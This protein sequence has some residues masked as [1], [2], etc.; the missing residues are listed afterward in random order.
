MCTSV[1]EIKCPICNE[2]IDQNKNRIIVELCG[3]SKCRLCFIT[4]ENGCVVC[5]K[6]KL[7]T[8][9]GI[10]IG[11]EKSTKSGPT[12]NDEQQQEYFKDEN[13]KRGSENA[14][15]SDTNESDPAVNATD[16]SKRVEIL[17]DVIIFPKTVEPEPHQQQSELSTAQVSLDEVHPSDTEGPTTSPANSIQIAIRK[18]KTDERLRT[19]S[20]IEVI[21]VDQKIS[22]KCLICQKQFKSRN[23]KK[24]HLYC[25]RKLTRPLKCDKCDKTFITTFHLQYHLKTHQ[26][27]E[28]FA[29]SQCDRKYLR[30][31]SLKKHIKKHRSEYLFGNLAGPWVL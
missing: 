4:E 31:I 22:F 25:D 9:Q 16:L 1:T 15:H 12:K 13:S 6:D 8:V 21:N 10:S 20:H 11:I 19:Q 14:P 30:E 18:P 2:Y 7:P 28:L 29:C 3:H 24:Y 26:S 17:E 27:T 5:N 23:N